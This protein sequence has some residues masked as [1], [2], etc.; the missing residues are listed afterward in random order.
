MT[1]YNSTDVL[2][3]SNGIDM[4]DMKFPFLTIES[5]FDMTR[6]GKLFPYD[7]ILG[8]SPDVHGDNYLTLGVPL[9]IHLK[10]INK[11][12][13]AI[14]GVN[15]YKNSANATIEFGKIDPGK[16]R[17]KTE[18]INDLYWLSVPTNTV[19]FAWRREMRNVF[20]NGVSFDDGNINDAVFDSFYG[21]IYL[22]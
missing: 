11:I 6:I 22:P 15:M 9:P 17:N 19:Q 12:E 4:I 10:N 21:G 20:Y 1:G 14:V 16:L 8:L 3:W 13:K 18:T 2:Y 5:C 7:G